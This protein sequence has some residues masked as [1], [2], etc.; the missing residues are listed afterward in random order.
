MKTDY[1]KVQQAVSL[2][3]ESGV[4]FMLA[5]HD[6][7][8]NGCQTAASGKYVDL[9]SCTIGIMARLALRIKENGYNGLDT[10]RE[11]MNM[12]LHT[13][14]LVAEAEKKEEE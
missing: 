6:E 13:V 9:K 14:E 3:E 1:E 7:E 10:I 12:V 4:E 8:N 5:Y 2:L 11:L